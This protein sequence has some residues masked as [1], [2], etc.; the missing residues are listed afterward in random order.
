MSYIPPKNG[1]ANRNERRTHPTVIETVWKPRLDRLLSE[2]NG[3]QRNDLALQYGILK[4]R[5]L[6]QAVLLGMDEGEVIALAKAFGRP[7]LRRKLA[8]LEGVPR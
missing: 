4:I 3:R 5:Q 2:L 8:Q 1:S 7:V 6:P